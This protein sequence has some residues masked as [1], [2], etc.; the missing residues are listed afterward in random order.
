MIRA[1]ALR[2]ACL[3]F[4]CCVASVAVTAEPVSVLVRNGPP[5]R[6]VDLAIV[7]DGYTA[8][9]MQKF[10]DD[11]AAVANAYF[12]EPPYDEYRRYFNVR[13]IE[14]ASAQS[15]ADHP[16]GNVFR[17]TAFDAA[18]DCF[19]IDRLICVDTGA[20][21]AVLDASG[22]TPAQRDMVWVLVN[23][24]RYGG[25]GG[26]VAVA[27][28]HE[29]VVDLLLHEAGHSFGFL[30]DEYTYSPPACENTVEP[31][32]PNVTIQAARDGIK[33]THWIAGGTPLPTTAVTSALPGLYQGA[34]YCVSG[35]YRPTYASAMAVLGAPFEQVNE[36]QLVKRIYNFVSPIDRRSPVARDVVVAAGTQQ[37]FSV[38]TPRPASHRLRTSW[39]L[40]GV[41]Q[42][43]AN[44]RRSF[45]VDT[46]LLRPGTH[47]VRAQV[48]DATPKVRNDPDGLLAATTV[49]TLIVE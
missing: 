19:G 7:G 34:R 15:G 12:A 30:A 14:V 37:E 2:G 47:R 27:S 6:R 36:E 10:R 41:V 23:D 49:W 8:G 25:S 26:A 42:A 35:M 20:V 3:A 16:S 18:Y 45:T 1:H 48:R 31:A 13:A 21:Y 43:A 22:V 44:N 33:W 5:A 40:D 24:S 39:T 29:S 17:D 32:E 46:G 28:T 9:E 4:L 11:A 38:F